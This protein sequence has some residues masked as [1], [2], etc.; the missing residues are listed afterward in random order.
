MAKRDVTKTPFSQKK[1][2][3]DSSEIMAADVKLMLRKVLKVPCRYL[4]PFLGYRENPVGGRLCPPPQLTLRGGDLYTFG[5][6]RATPTSKRTAAMHASAPPAWERTMCWTKMFRCELT[7]E[8]FRPTRAF[9]R[10]E[11]EGLLLVREAL[12]R[13]ER[14]FV[15]LQGRLSV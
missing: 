10:P 4:P 12:C 14:P 15:G 3:T 5:I 11:R 1:N 13:P 6:A 9:R 8:I 2:S 7:W